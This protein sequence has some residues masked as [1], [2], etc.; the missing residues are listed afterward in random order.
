M[1]RDTLLTSDDCILIAIDIQNAFLDKLEPS[2]KENLLKRACWL[3]EVARWL[4]IPRVVTAE[5][6]T[7]LGSV[8]QDLQACLS[9][10]EIYDKLTFSLAAQKDILD[11]VK[12]TKRKTCIL[13]GLE[14][15]VCIAQSAF[16]L[17]QEGYQVAVIADATCSPRKAHQTGL[18][19]IENAGGLIIQTKAL[20]YEWVRTVEKAK[21]FRL[22][23]PG[24]A[25]PDSF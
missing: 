6:M 24:L 23:R 1:L 21:E 2:Q 11:A 17:L 25:H 16:G 5:D 13:I 8:H 22:E 9:D 20:Y 3:I 10:E 19:R 14:T 7:D 12:K 18:Q 15:D 4:N